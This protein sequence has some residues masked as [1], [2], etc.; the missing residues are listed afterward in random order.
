M[1]TGTKEIHL[2]QHIEDFLIKQDHYETVSPQQ[3]NKELCLIPE[4]IIAFIKETQ[5]EKY[6]KVKDNLG[7]QT[8]KKLVEYV[9]N[10]MFKRIWFNELYDRKVRG[11]AI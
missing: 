6:N 1:A 8:D 5:L 7:N 2:E 11:I 3:Y 4:E 10:T 9:A